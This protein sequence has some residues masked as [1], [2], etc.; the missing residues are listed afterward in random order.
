MAVFTKLNMIE[1]EDFLQ[2][3]SIGKLE[4]YSEVE[5]KSLIKLAI[6]HK[7]KI[8]SSTIYDKLNFI[9]IIS[10]YELLNPNLKFDSR[11]YIVQDDFKDN[12]I[13]YNDVKQNLLQKVKKIENVIGV[14][15]NNGLF[16]QENK[17]KIYNIQTLEDNIL[18]NK[19]IKECYD[20]LI[21]NSTETL[22]S[23]KHLSWN[24]YEKKNKD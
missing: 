4:D 15:T 24:I 14:I 16:L 21:V 11:L 5:I 23:L 17:L 20:I 22:V 2:N 9:Q 8:L 13:L 1:V 18:E 3:Y 7:F 6:H 10:I 19:I 12:E